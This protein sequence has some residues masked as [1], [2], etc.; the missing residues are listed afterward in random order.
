MRIND[1]IIAKEVRLIGPN[2]DMM[3]IMTP[4][5]ARQIAYQNDL[6]LVEISPKANPPVCKVIDYG[7]FMF[8]QTKKQKEALKHQKATAMKEVWLKPNIE[9]HDFSFKTKNANKFLSQGH[10][11]KVSLR[12]RGREM[13]YANTGKE[14]M[15]KFAEA[16][17]ET[18]EL[19]S[20]P[21]LEGRNMLM[22]ISPLK[23]K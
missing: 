21:K 14:L 13:A 17:S 7:K 3:G 23:N 19:D 16:C 9:E 4:D 6:D 10:K 20:N 2:G 12:F 11:V 1:D 8:D 18:G 15:L 5:K 22:T